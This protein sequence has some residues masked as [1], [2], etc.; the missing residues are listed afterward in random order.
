MKKLI[1]ILAL[2]AF[3][4]GIG[5]FEEL[6]LNNTTDKLYTYTDELHM[7]IEQDEEHIDSAKNKELYKRL[8]DFWMDAEKTLCLLVNYENIKCITEAIAKLEIS[9]DENDLSVTHENIN[10]LK[11]YS[12]IMDNVYGFSIQNLL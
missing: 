12:K 1:T 9:I 6:F 3:I 8:K 2:A 5:V 4:I 11:Y 10:A 7:S